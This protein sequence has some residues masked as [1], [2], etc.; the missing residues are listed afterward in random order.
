M[1]VRERA[2][3]R[4]KTVTLAG[5]EA[6]LAW[7][8]VA[9]ALLIV[10]ALVV[11]PIVWNVL[12]SLQRVRLRDLQTINFLDLNLSL[13]NFDRVIGVR[14]FWDTLRTTVAYAFFGTV[15][16]LAM[17]VWAALVV[18]KAFIGRSLVRGLMLFPYVA[19]VIAVTFLWRIMLNPQF[20]IINEWIDDAGIQRIDFLGRRSFELG[21]FGWQLTLPVA[22]TAVIVFEAWRYFPFAF[23]FILARLQ[24][25]PQDLEEAAMVDGA[26]LSQRFRYVTLPQLRGVLSVLFVLRFIWT[27]NKFDDVYLLTGGSA[28]TEVITV[29]IVDWLQ[30]RADVG[31]AAALSIVLA[32]VLMV[33][34]AIYFKWFYEEEGDAT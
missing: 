14:D 18:K 32:G 4:R 28:G 24:A 10:F 8:L 22:L 5:R 7:I 23:L 29:K 20:G 27:F 31:S 15:L 33:L 6:R 3:S 12:L 26:T 2:P 21:I 9:P 34:L 13:D 1:S 19:P 17:G 16:S 30:G 25:M 11:F